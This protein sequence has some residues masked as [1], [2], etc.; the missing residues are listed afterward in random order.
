MGSCQHL[1]R[2]ANLV[3]LTQEATALAAVSQPL[4]SKAP[5]G[6]SEWIIS[7][8]DYVNNSF[9]ALGSSDPREVRL[10]L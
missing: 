1:D 8:G 2:Q 7:V 6:G 4:M 10:E 3:P 9:T 5:P